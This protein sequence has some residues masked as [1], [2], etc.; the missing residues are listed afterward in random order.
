MTTLNIKRGPEFSRIL[1][2]G[3]A[4]GEHAVPNDDLIEPINS[5]DE[6][7]RKMTGIATRVRAD[8]DTS[9]LDLSENAAREAIAN[10]GISA[11]EID[12]VILST[13]TYPHMT[14]GGA[15]I[16]ADRLGITAAAYDISAACAGY[17]YGI[18]QADAFVRAG[19]ARN[20]L[21][22]GAEKMSDYVDPTDRSISYLLG[23]AAGAV[24][25]GAS[26]TPGIGP[27]V[28]GSDGSGSRLIR[29]TASWLEV[30]DNPETPFPT[31]FQE[32]PSVFKWASFKMAPIALEAIEAAGVTP[33]DIK[34]FIPHQANVRIIDQMVKQIGLP[35][36]VVVGKD[37]VDSGNTSAA[38]IPLA[39]ERLY[40]DGQV[41][42]GDLALQIGFGAGLVYAAQVV[43][44]P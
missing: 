28:W 40:R 12:T 17:C 32:G 4:R 18:A 39:T 14:P 5:S 24:V 23:D 9:V 31:L 33:A 29:Q 27:T 30:R 35:D 1:G 20:V 37:I 3:V 10:A 22:I 43:V 36:T 16:V 8:K 44:L 11:D 25:I 42:P 38:S 6:W 34:A 26:D 21:V 19:T 41:K 2:L 7:I 13:I 15:P